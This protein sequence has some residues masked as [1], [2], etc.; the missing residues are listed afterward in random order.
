[1]GVSTEQRFKAVDD[2]LLAVLP[3]DG[4]RWYSKPFLLR[5]NFSIASLV[6]FGEILFRPLLMILSPH[7]S[8]S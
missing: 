2:A 6:I 5:L 4:R 1:M 3:Q 7:L 8:D